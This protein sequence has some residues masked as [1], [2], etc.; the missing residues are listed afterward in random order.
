MAKPGHS[1]PHSC[2]SAKQYHPLSPYNNAPRTRSKRLFFSSPFLLLL[3]SFV[4]LSSTFSS[5]ITEAA[6]PARRSHSGTALLDKVHFVGGLGTAALTD[7]TPLKSI[8]TLDLLTGNTTEIALTQGIYNHASSTTPFSSDKYEP[9]QIGLGFGQTTGGVPMGALDWVGP[10]LGN[11]IAAPNVTTSGPYAQQPLAARAGHSMVQY[12]T[13]NLWVFGGYTLPLNDTRQP[14]RDTPTFDYSSNVWSNQ[15]KIGL[16]RYGHA[17]AV[18]STDNII[19]CYGTLLYPLKEKVVVPTSECVSF[20]IMKTTFT[21]INLIFSNADDTIK[22]GLIGHSLVASPLKNGKLYMFGGTNENGDTY[23]QNLYILDTTGLPN[24]WIKKVTPTYD[25][26][27]VPSAR[28]DHVAVA[29]GAQDGFMI[30]HGGVTGPNTMA[31]GEAYYYYMATDKWL[32]VPTF[33]ER[34][35]AQQL[36]AQS[37][38]NPWILIA[39][40]LIG[41]SLLGGCVVVYIWRGIR[42]DTARRLEREAADRQSMASPDFAAMDAAAAENRKSGSGLSGK[43]G[44]TPHPIYG[45]T[46]EDDHSLSNGPFMSTSSLIQA[47]NSAKKTKSKGDNTYHS[48]HSKPWVTEPASPGGTTLTENGSIN[49]YYSSNSSQTPSRLNK[50]GSNASSQNSMATRNN[51]NTGNNNQPGTGTTSESYYNPRDLFVDDDDSSITVSL[52]SETSTNNM[53]PW[54]GPVRVSTDLAPPNPRFSR[55]AI[56]QAHRQLVDA[57]AIGAASPM[58]S[59]YAFSSSRNSNGWDTSSPGGSL[60]SRDDEYHRRS[61]NSMQWVSFEPMDLAGRPESQIYDPLSH[62]QQQ[63]RSGNSNGGGLTIRNNTS[64]YRTSLTSQPIIIP[65]STQNNPRMSMFGGS[66]TSDTNTEDSGSY[67]G[68]GGKRISTALATRQQRRSI[69]NSQDS[70]NSASGGRHHSYQQQQQQQQQMTNNNSGKAGEEEEVFVTKVL[71]I[72]TNKLTKPTLAKVVTQQR[73]SRIVVP[74]TGP[75]SDQRSPL[76]QPSEEGTGLG[77]DFSGFSTSQDTYMS[78][79]GSG[80]GVNSNSSP[81]RTSYQTRRTSNLN[82]NKPATNNSRQQQRDSTNVILKMPPAPK[83]TDSNSGG[84]GGGSS[85]LNPRSRD[86]QQLQ[87]DPVARNSI[88][89]VGQELSGYF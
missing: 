10:V 85:S 63:Q 1:T 40:I 6:P 58:P 41:V 21:K 4:L 39:G 87:A 14:A 33:V 59:A 86:Q 2:P 50:K 89:D 62:Q 66:N 28:S 69:R 68:P 51:N 83:H 17:S 71:P 19:S 32:D 80:S 29:V 64:M 79:Y 61:V 3:A 24:V 30:I 77:I 67:Y 81:R 88:M 47:E 35:Q 16:Y 78:G 38:V 20:S 12:E 73:G 74:S 5:S 57:I 52:A 43:K 45:M 31:D 23:N 70:L 82:P 15:T 72:I 55:G 48:N 84:G 34:Y 49:G 53:S 42:K 22:G 11:V 25:M 44:R 8:T 60:S 56:P 75:L 26:A 7:T 27:L 54:T 18:A 36:T 37:E 46:E 65:S 76:S 13:N 9:G